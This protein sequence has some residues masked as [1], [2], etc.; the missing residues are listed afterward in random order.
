VRGRSGHASSSMLLRLVIRE[1][2]CCEVRW[3]ARLGAHLVICVKGCLERARERAR[4]IPSFEF[5]PVTTRIPGVVSATGTTG[6][7]LHCNLL[8]HADCGLPKLF[9]T[10][11]DASPHRSAIG[12]ERAF[13]ATERM[14]EDNKVI[15]FVVRRERSVVVSCSRKGRNCSLI[16]DV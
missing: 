2:V 1:T 9:V 14:R 12:A 11:V 10:V 7:A 6:T 4:A 15:N 5:V 16:C 3:G 13:G 8:R